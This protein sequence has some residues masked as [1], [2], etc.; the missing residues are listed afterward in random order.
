M[1][2]PAASPVGWTLFI[3]SIFLDEASQLHPDQS[4]RER[5]NL[6]TIQLHHINIKRSHCILHLLFPNHCFTC[7]ECFL[8][9]SEGWTEQEEMRKWSPGDKTPETHWWSLC[10]C[11]DCH[12]EEAAAYRVLSK[13]RILGSYSLWCHKYIHLLEFKYISHKNQKI[14]FL[15]GNK[16][17]KRKEKKKANSAGQY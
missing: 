10:Y 8:L 4:R 2:I 16:K 12:A 1:H 14:Y 3:N 13:T 15:E 6:K 7:W 5:K 17:K 11:W 9:G